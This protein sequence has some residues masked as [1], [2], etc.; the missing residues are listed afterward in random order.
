[1]AS[2]KVDLMVAKM[3]VEMVFL[4]GN[5]LVEQKDAIMVVMMVSLMVDD[6]E[7]DLVC[8]KVMKKVS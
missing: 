6:L 4:M 2:E 7:Y 8:E 5:L 1:M 3:V